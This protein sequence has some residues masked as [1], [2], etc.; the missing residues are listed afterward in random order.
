MS[1]APRPPTTTAPAPT[2]RLPSLLVF[3]V[4]E[5]L[6]DMSPLGAAFAAV[7]LAEH[8]ATA[9]FASV[10]RD[11]FALT[12]IGDNVAFATMAAESLSVVVSRT[13]GADEDAAIETVTSALAAL[14]VHPDVPRGL[15]QL[16]ELGLR[17]V[18][19]SN[20][21]ASVAEALMNRTEA[22]SGLFERYLSVEDAPA[23]KPDPRAYTYAL[24]ACGVPAADTMLVAVHPWDIAGAHRAGLRTAW[25]NRTH[26][27][28]PAY[29]P[30]PDIT[31]TSLPDLAATLRPQ[32]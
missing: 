2:A 13:A 22:T 12:L 26:A 19:L 24:G 27:P 20:G 5:T 29:F 21:A 14:D 1:A 7:G 3:D 17:M 8:D 18:T 6:S 11:A 28:Y 10:L 16:H 31:L 9:W 23:W 30:P 32:P 4:N 15:T 25:L